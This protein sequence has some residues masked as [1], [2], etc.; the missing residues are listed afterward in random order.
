M[1]GND[2]MK[3]DFSKMKRV[4]IIAGGVLF[5]VVLAAVGK[6]RVWCN[7]I[8]PA[9][10]L[11]TALSAKSVCRHKVGEGC[12]NC[13]ACFRKAESPA[14]AQDGGNGM[15]RRE[16]LEGVAVLAAAEAVEKTIKANG[17]T[18]V[19]PATILKEHPSFILYIDEDSASGILS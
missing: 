16:A 15:T 13:R 12:A 4:M 2:M 6:G 8:C 11:F 19:V 1:D 9:G 14:K 7:W 3:N 10:T 18:N 17:T 5:V